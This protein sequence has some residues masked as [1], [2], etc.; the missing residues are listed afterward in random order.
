MG[1]RLSFTESVNVGPFVIS[2]GQISEPGATKCEVDVLARVTKWGE[3]TAN[4]KSISTSNAKQAIDKFTA[5]KTKAVDMV[6]VGLGYE[7]G[8]S[9]QSSKTVEY[10]GFKWLVSPENCV[11]EVDECYGCTRKDIWNDCA[12]KGRISGSGRCDFKF[13]TLGEVCV[14]VKKRVCVENCDVESN[15]GATAS[16][17]ATSFRG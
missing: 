14:D 5:S 2:N 15:S 7:K 10:E 4:I 13:T 6:S 16:S 9:E 8:S 1:E 17:G 12:R 3:D 11:A